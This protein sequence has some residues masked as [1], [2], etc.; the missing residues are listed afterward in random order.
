MATA[1]AYQHGG[2]M[3]KLDGISSVILIIDDQPAN[4]RLLVGMVEALGEVLFATSPRAGLDL[5]RTRRPDLILLDVEM[6]ELNGYEVL[7]QLRSDPET[8]SIAVVIVTAHTS[9]EHEIQALNAGALDFIPRPLNP[10]VVQTRV[11]TQPTVKHQRDELRGLIRH[12]SLTGVY[13]RRHFDEVA[14]I[15]RCIRPRHPETMLA[16]TWTPCRHRVN[17][18]LDSPP[19]CRRGKINP[20]Q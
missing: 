2:P 7:H 19:R 16:S 6:P 5:V 15:A 8:E 18:F 1:R 3:R 17:R 9:P 11:R 13:N 14:P 20:A 10:L 12:D 4:I